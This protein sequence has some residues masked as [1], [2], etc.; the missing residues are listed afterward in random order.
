MSSCTGKKFSCYYQYVRQRTLR[1]GP[2]AALADIKRAYQTDAYVKTQCHELVHV[3][4]AAATEKFS[5]L[6]DV[7]R[8]DDPMCQNGYRHGAEEAM[9][10]Q[11]KGS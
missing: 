4:G 10:Q 1:D 6:Q 7:L 9:A 2:T 8:Y 5:R 3:V 11:H